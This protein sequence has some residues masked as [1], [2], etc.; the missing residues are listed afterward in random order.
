MIDVDAGHI[1]R[2]R[3]VKMIYVGLNAVGIAPPIEIEIL[4]QE[5]IGPRMLA[6]K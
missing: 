5:L 2:A 4:G 3:R 1:E 6:N